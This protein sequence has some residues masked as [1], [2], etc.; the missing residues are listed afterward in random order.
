MTLHGDKESLTL[1]LLSVW[2]N[3]LFFIGGLLC[4]DIFNSWRHFQFRLGKIVWSNSSGKQ[5]Y[6]EQISLFRSTSISTYQ[7]Y[8]MSSAS[9]VLLTGYDDFAVFG[10]A[11]RISV[12]KNGLQLTI[13]RFEEWSKLTGFTFSPSKTY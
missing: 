8:L 2:S 6:T 10:P 11:R 1:S 12:T 4:E 7:H 3:I 9:D 5:Y 13:C